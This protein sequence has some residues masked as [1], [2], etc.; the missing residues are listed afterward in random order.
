MG[1][2]G[3]KSK[4]DLYRDILY[5]TPHCCSQTKPKEKKKEVPASK[6]VRNSQAFLNKQVDMK[7]ITGSST[8]IRKAEMSN[9]ND[10][11]V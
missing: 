11:K 5:L 1:D 6:T 3:K 9:I 2:T 4:G 7:N 8:R 10:P